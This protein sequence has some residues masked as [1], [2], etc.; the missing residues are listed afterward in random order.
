MFVCGA[1]RS[2]AD[3]VDTARRGGRQIAGQ[4][5]VGGVVFSGCDRTAF[6]GLRSRA[7]PGRDCGGSG[8][9]Q[10]CGAAGFAFRGTGVIPW[11]AGDGCERRGHRLSRCEAL[12]SWRMSMR[13]WRKKRG[14]QAASRPGV[15][16]RR[17]GPHLPSECAVDH[18]LTGSGASQVRSTQSTRPATRSRAWS[19]WESTRRVASNVSRGPA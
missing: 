15:T 5:R 16:V 9:K 17:L 12:L 10:A 11:L 4:R 14:R 1:A 3:G 7:R 18:P 8:G 6:Q 19:I 13:G 2:A